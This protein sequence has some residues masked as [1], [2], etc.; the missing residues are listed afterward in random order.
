[1]N[2]NLELFVSF[3]LAGKGP[4]LPFWAC[5][6]QNYPPA[7]FGRFGDE[8]WLGQAKINNK[9]FLGIGEH[10]QEGEREGRGPVPNNGRNGEK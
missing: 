8:R 6:S 9:Y 5:P 10:Q 1:M 2:G 7:D 3:E 4:S